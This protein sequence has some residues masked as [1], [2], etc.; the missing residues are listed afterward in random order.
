VYALRDPILA[1]VFNDLRAYFFAHLSE[2]LAQL[3]A[4]QGEADSSYDDGPSAR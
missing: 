1:K 4:E 2:A 3:R